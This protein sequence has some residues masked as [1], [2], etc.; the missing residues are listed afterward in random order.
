V[1]LNAKAIPSFFKDMAAL[2]LEVFCLPEV[3]PKS[4]AEVRSA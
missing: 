1:G 3:R 2:L 4:L